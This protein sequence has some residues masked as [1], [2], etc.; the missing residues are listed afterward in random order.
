LNPPTVNTKQS[1]YLVTHYVV[2]AETCRS[3]FDL[4]NEYKIIFGVVLHGKTEP[5]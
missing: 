3:K 4:K 5:G 2:P 1:W